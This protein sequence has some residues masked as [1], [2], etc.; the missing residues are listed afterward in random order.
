MYFDQMLF[1]LPHLE[2]R[3]THSNLS[4]DRSQ[5]EGDANSSQEEQK[6]RPRN[7]RKTRNEMSYE[8][9]LLQILRQINMDDSNVDEDKC[10]LLSLLPSF[11]QFNDDQ[12]YLARMEILKIMRHVKLQKNV[13]MYAS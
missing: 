2:D 12:K 6:K 1:L 4:D 5:H 8:E 11:S 13:D 10:F 3:E 7:L 9:A